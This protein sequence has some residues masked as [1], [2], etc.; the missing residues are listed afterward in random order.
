MKKRGFSL[1][2]LM[3]VIVII[4]VVYSLALSKLQVAKETKPLPS[5]KN[6]KAYVASFIEDG[7]RATLECKE[8]KKC[9][10]YRDGKKITE[11]ESFF[12]KSIEMYRYDFFL[13]ETALQRENCFE[14]SM[15]RDGVGDQVIVVY[16]EKAYDYTPFFVPVVSYDSLAELK[17]AKEELVSEVMQ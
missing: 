2:E 16:K 1:I 8:C 11:V 3:I 9:W 7:K 15:D 13:G 10:I 14:F 6:L 17:S 12:D 4:G 5:L